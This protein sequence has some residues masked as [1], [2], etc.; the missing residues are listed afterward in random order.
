MMPRRPLA[1]VA[2]IVGAISLAGCVPEPAPTPTPTGFASEEEAFAAAEETYRAYIEATNAVIL[3]DPKT[4]ENV[5]E[6][7]VEKENAELRELFSQMHAD[8]WTV[9]G[10]TKYDTFSGV[11]FSTDGG[12]TVAMLCLDV[13]DVDVVD[14]EGISLVTEERLDRQPLEVAFEHA[15][16]RTGY[17]I[18]ESDVA[19]DYEC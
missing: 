6:W 4:F 8:G 9:T 15:S 16:T 19:G 17:A 2:A 11:S 7:A 3:S 1:L 14:A 12:R 18:A 10:E 13:T 5:Y